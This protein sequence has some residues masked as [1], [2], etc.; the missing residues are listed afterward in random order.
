M[1]KQLLLLQSLII[2]NTTQKRQPSGAIIQSFS[3]RHFYDYYCPNG[4]VQTCYGAHKH[5]P[6]HHYCQHVL[7]IHN[8]N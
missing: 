1:N 6:S 5:T 8:Y 3:N 4:E 2:P 7:L